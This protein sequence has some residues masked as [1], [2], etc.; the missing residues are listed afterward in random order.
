MIRKRVIWHSFHS[1]PCGNV[2]IQTFALVSSSV[3]ASSYHIRTLVCLL[4]WVLNELTNFGRNEIGF[5]HAIASVNILRLPRTLLSLVP[6]Q[7]E[8]CR[9]HKE[10]LRF[11]KSGLL[12][13]FV[14]HSCC[15]GIGV[16]SRRRRRIFHQQYNS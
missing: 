8:T 4:C 13:G 2:F 14:V 9:H 6:M 3:L 16:L 11:G 12:C 1:Q 10:P 7:D 15:S 5:R